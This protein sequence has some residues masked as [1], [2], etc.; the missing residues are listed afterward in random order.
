VIIN[1]QQKKSAVQI[2]ISSAEDNEDAEGNE[3]DL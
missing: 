2:D 3:G 1:K